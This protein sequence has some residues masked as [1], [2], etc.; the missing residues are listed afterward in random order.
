MKCTMLATGLDPD[1]S[2]AGI[3]NWKYFRVLANAGLLDAAYVMEWREDQKAQYPDFLRCV[4]LAPGMDRGEQSLNW[5]KRKADALRAVLTGYPKA[6]CGR[7]CAWEHVTSQYARNGRGGNAFLALGGGSNFTPHIALS[8]SGKA[9]WIGHYHDPY[10]AHLY[11][12]PYK[13]KRTFQLGIQERVHEE[14]LRCA[15]ALTFPC[16]RLLQWVL[17]GKHEVYRSKAFVLPHLWL[18]EDLLAGMKEESMPFDRSCFHVVHCGTLLRHREPWA[19]LRAFAKFAEGGADRGRK[20][21]LWFAGNVH[22]AIAREPLWQ[23]S[24]TSGWLRVIDER[25]PY[26]RALSLS[27]KADLN[28]VLEADS[29]ESPFF[30][31]K[32]A[33]LLG[34]GKPILAITPRYSAVRDILGTSYPLLCLPNEEGQIL[35]ALEVTWE[36][37]RGGIMERLAPSPTAREATSVETALREF[38]RL[39][40]FLCSAETGGSDGRG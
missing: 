32:L 18:A 2:S 3:Q 23:W 1:R 40:E 33:D 35:K 26:L 24:A 4:Q 39:L 27:A 19:L 22:P 17:K 37:W 12:L 20:V 36:C 25:L 8:R 13:A 30:P 11:P 14:I 6:L 31:G 7:I 21:Y 5:I 28:V 16:R 15:T 10:P 34:V 29:P 9:L 38:A